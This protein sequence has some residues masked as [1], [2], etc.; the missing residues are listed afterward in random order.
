MVIVWKIFPCVQSDSEKHVLFVPS[1][2][3]CGVIQSYGM[4]RIPR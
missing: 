3:L 4:P 1:F 2:L